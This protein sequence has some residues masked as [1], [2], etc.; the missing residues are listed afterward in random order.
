VS[1]DDAR[2]ADASNRAERGSR[3]R[4]APVGAAS[5]LLTAAGLCGPPA[6]L[7]PPLAAAQ[8]IAG[9]VP[10]EVEPYQG[11]LVREVRVEGLS[12]V[13]ERFV[14]NQLRTV[15]GRPLDWETVQRDL[16][17]I[18]RIG[19]FR[20]AE[21]ALEIAEDLSVAVVFRVVEAPI[22]EDIEVVGNRRL[23]DAELSQAIARVTLLT[24]VPIDDYRIGAAARSI[25]Q[26]YRDEGYYQ[27]E[28]TVDE[29]ELAETG[30]VIFRIREGERVRLTGIRFAGNRA[31][32][33]RILR[34]QVRSEVRGLLNAGPL[35]DELL[36][37]DVRSL[38]EFYR[39]RGYLDVR[40]SRSIRPAPDGREAI[41]TFVVDEGP[42]YILRSVEVLPAGADLAD[43]RPTGGAAGGGL[44]VLSP[45]QARGLMT[46][47]PGDVLSARELEASIDRVRNALRQMGYIDAEV[48]R[49]TFK[50][51]RTDEVDLRLYLAEGERFRTGV[52]R[53][54]GHDLTKSEVV[55]REVEVLPD[56]PLDGT[57]IEQSERNLRQSGVFRRPGPG[58]RGP[59][60]TLQQFDPVYPGYRDVLVEVEETR[61]GRIGF[62]ASAS[63][64][65]GVVGAIN[66]VERNFDITDTPDSLGELVR[67]QAFRG[68]G[69]TF[70][71]AL[72]PGDRV[73]EYSIG[74][75][76]PALFETD[77]TGSV[78][79]FFREREYDDFDEQRAGGR[80]TF[81]RRFGTRWTG[82]L[83]LRA[84][85]IDIG[86]IEDSATVDLFEVEGDNALT[87][88]GFSLER[89]T[90]DDR[91]LP[92]RGTV[93]ELSIEQVGALGGDYQFTRLGAGHSVFIKVDEDYLARPTV[94]RLSTD[95]RYIPQD[96]EAPIFERFYLGGRSF[97][98]FD[99]RGI[100]PVGVRNDTGN[101]G[102]DKVGGAFSFFLGAELQK[103]LIGDF[104][105][106]VLF[107]DTGTLNE[108][109][110]FEDYRVSVGTGV[111]VRVPALGPVPIALDFGIP[112]VQ[113][114]TDEQRIFTFF[115]DIPF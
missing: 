74:L 98:G 20:S 14:V 112:I 67:G 44:D 100:G 1:D 90:T 106:G 40:V 27:A 54:K 65:A 104:L 22:V 53:T 80:L 88:L 47:A 97:R 43:G 3:A 59:S 58:Y 10:D 113:E 57:A 33:S 70:Q 64:D 94:L 71:L 56:H 93:T 7:A 49:E 17:N 60:L 42:L 29:S 37:N 5:V 85:A 68:A 39:D 12:R 23:R 115:V 4:R 45:A 61:T 21:A 103:P 95:A 31:F 77:Y 63:S 19:E 78:S 6:L 69:Q 50:D 2:D 30:A 75:T 28:V 24:G 114:D 34:E 87:S 11:R 102:N 76:E 25:E 105:T 110:S 26:L 32:P 109:L 55:L 52:V 18:E 86:S 101:L 91:F 13:P 73:S 89:N 8:D 48:R 96:D 62:G 35:D 83:A 38:I 9:E 84:E 92:T 79:A 107:M 66:V 41:V 46:I 51:P 72:Q 82:R 108:D 16:R 111:R 15:S 36:D 81:G 99:F